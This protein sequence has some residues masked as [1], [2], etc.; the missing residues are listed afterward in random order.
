[1]KYKTKII[2]QADKYIGQLLSEEG[3]VYT[4]S[5]H[6]DPVM[7]SRELANVVAKL[8]PSP[9][10]SPIPTPTQSPNLVSFPNNHGPGPVDPSTFVP[11]QPNPP[12]YQYA[13]PSPTRKCCGRG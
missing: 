6:N 13:P 10:P 8:T 11:V 1:M 3:V 5:V 2:P 4:T 7:V 12:Q 9:I